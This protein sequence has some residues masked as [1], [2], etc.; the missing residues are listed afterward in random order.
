[1]TATKTIMAG[2]DLSGYSPMTLNSTI[3][4]IFRHSPVPVLRLGPDIIH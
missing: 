1:M 3:E 4:K 2:I